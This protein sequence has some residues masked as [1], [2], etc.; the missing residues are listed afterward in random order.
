MTDTTSARRPRQALPTFLTQ[1]ATADLVTA[2]LFEAARE[3]DRS[4]P[5]GAALGATIDGVVGE[6]V[7]GGFGTVDPRRTSTGSVR[8]I[9]T[10]T[11]G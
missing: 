8:S 3:Q 4:T 11:D 9:G 1:S 6:L 5:V 2:V 10:G 7:D